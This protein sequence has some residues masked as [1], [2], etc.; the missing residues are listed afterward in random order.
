MSN[1]FVTVLCTILCA[2]LAGFVSAAPITGAIDFTGNAVINEA[3]LL[4]GDTVISFGDVTTLDPEDRTRDI[5]ATINGDL[6][7]GFFNDITVVGGNIVTP[8][9]PLW[10]V[11]EGIATGGSTVSFAMTAATL[12][13]TDIPGFGDSLDAV[14]IYGTGVLSMDGF[15]DTAGEFY[16][17]SQRD[18]VT[19]SASAEAVSAP[20]GLAL[21]GMGLVA[22]GVK[23]AQKRS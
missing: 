11:T 7:G 6:T 3:E 10:S 15:D 22:L 9:A 8:I 5:L 19:F 13:L 1:R 21:L 17:S 4:A 16:Y 12:V 23:R 18:Q 2:S 14:E 20:S